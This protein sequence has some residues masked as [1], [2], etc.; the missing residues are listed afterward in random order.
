L[1]QR[2]P[3]LLTAARLLPLSN[4]I[5]STTIDQRRGTPMSLYRFALAAL[6]ALGS[7]A[8]PADSAPVVPAD[9]IEASFCFVSNEGAAPNTT[10]YAVDRDEAKKRAPASLTYCKDGPCTYDGSL[11]P[12]KEN[13]TL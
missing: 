13:C 8:L 5:E 11:D 4:L 10:V 2:V 3:G 12:E 9:K 6:F 7:F 1:H